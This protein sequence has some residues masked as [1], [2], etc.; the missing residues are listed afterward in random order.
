MKYIRKHLEETQ[1]VLEKIDSD[2][3]QLVSKVDLAKT[4][5]DSGCKIKIMAGASDV[6]RSTWDTLAYHQ[7]VFE[8]GGEGTLRGYDW[9]GIT[10]SHY[11]LNTIEVWFGSVGV[12]YDHV[13][14]FESPG[15]I[16]NATFIPN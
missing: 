3:K 4:I 7:N 8:I 1:R 2:K 12:L 5:K 16:F 9:K 13:I 15:N 10:S 14:L 6:K 11:Q